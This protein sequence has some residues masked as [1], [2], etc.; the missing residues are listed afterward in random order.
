MRNVSR[1]AAMHTTQLSGA[2]AAI[3]L[4][5]ASMRRS[6]STSLLVGL[7]SSGRAQVCVGKRAA[8]RPLH[9]CWWLCMHANTRAEQ[10]CSPQLGNRRLQQL[11]D[12]LQLPQRQLP[13]RFQG[14]VMWADHVAAAGHT[15]E[16][17]HST[18]SHGQAD[19]PEARAPPAH[20]HASSLP[21][22]HRMRLTSTLSSLCSRSSSPW[23]P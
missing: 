1:G 14:T 7:G 15:D 6:V 12:L 17:M 19:H 9:L 2:A 16:P 3:S 22:M 13:V 21:S 5:A 11:H 4:R 23:A 10:G 20:L 18:A 8:P